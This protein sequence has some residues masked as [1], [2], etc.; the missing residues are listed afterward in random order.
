[1]TEAMDLRS[2]LFVLCVQKDRHRKCL[3]SAKGVGFGVKNRETDF[4]DR[5]R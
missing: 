4:L 2:I 1:M 5:N 3:F